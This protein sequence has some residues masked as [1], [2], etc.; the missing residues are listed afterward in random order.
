MCEALT[1]RCELSGKM[2]INHHV[3]DGPSGRLSQSFSTTGI[4][5]IRRSTSDNTEG[6]SSLIHLTALEY[7]FL[8]NSTIA[9]MSSCLGR[10][11]WM[12]SIL[13]VS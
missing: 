11:S 3:H 7:T 5:P 13:D 10:L 2:G 4:F 8:C 6:D 9:E 1:W 12:C